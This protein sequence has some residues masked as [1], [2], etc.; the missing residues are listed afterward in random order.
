MTSDILFIIFAFIVTISLPLMLFVEIFI[1]YMEFPG[2]FQRI[3]F[4]RREVGLITLGA[5]VGLLPNVPVFFWGGS[6]MML[7]YGG[8]IIPIALSIYLAKR[9]GLNPWLIIGGIA[10]V[11]VVSY[12]VSRYEPSMGVIS[13]F[14][15]YLLPSVAAFLYSLSITVIDVRRAAPLAYIAGCMGTLIGADL[16]RLPQ[17]F[18]VAASTGQPFTGSIGGAGPLDLVYLSGLLALCLV[19]LFSPKGLRE[20]RPSLSRKESTRREYRRA[21][22]GSIDHFYAT[23]GRESAALAVKA[24]E[25]RTRMVG[26]EFGM[27]GGTEDVL[28]QLGIDPLKIND[29]L[30]L[31]D[32]SA[33]DR[34]ES[35]DTERCLRAVTMLLE[36]LDRIEEKRY[37][38]TGARAIAFTIDLLLMFTVLGGAFFL[39]SS[40]SVIDLSSAFDIV[41]WIL[42][43]LMW[44]LA[45]QAMYFTITEWL[46]GQSLG[47]WV[48]NIRVV[49]ED[50]TRCTLMD[51]FTRNAIRLFDML[52]FFIPYGLGILA[53]VKSSRRQRLGDYIS[54]TIVLK[55]A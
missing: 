16:V 33:S 39:L 53:I 40:Y 51:A 35:Y 55:C 30:L 29:Y 32:M 42:L 52:P 14:P 45:G 24:L 49:R 6:I 3:G 10:I 36:V 34:V 28:H 17:I 1:G 23:D 20:A 26:E 54:N 19:I 15:Y 21:L 12:S 5:M 48:M 47:K 38:S 43:F 25:T 13:E 22:Q 11:S 18:S 44:A 4:T 31:K 50:Q 41:Y 46:W 2:L 27:E 37:A 8:A 9:K 7:N